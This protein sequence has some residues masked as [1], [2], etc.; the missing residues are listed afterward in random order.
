MEAL[1]IE[2]NNKKVMQ[3]P[4]LMHCFRVAHLASALCDKMQFNPKLKQEIYISAVLHDIG[5][6]MIDKEL[7]NKNKS[8]TVVE[9]NEIKYHPEIGGIIACNMGQDPLVVK[10]IVHHHENYDG[11]GYPRRLKGN[12]IAIGA[13]I[14]RICDTYDALRMERPYKRSFSHEEALEEIL[15]EKE[16][17][18]PIFL[19]SFLKQDFRPWAGNRYGN[20]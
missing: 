15:S 1:N 17:Y 10:N 14:I 16:K 11:S 2:I 4:D 5:K 19:E 3:M 8:L 18:N 20:V 6:S 12:G 9:W 7:L 13:Q